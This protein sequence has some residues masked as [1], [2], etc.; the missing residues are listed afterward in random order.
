[1]SKIE[2]KTT[3]VDVTAPEI[4]LQGETHAHN[5]VVMEYGTGIRA[6]RTDKLN[7]FVIAGV[8]N[9]SIQFPS[10]GEIIIN[11]AAS[12]RIKTADTTDTAD[13]ELRTVNSRINITSE[14]PSDGGI[15]ARIRRYFNIEDYDGNALFSINL[16]STYTQ[17]TA[18]SILYLGEN[19]SVIS[20]QS[21]TSNK[22]ATRNDRVEM[23]NGTC[24]LRIKSS[25]NNTETIVGYTSSD[26]GSQIRLLKHNIRF[27]IPYSAEDSNGL[28]GQIYF[29]DSGNSGGYPFEASFSIKNETDFRNALDYIF[30]IPFGWVNAKLYLYENITLN[31]IYEHIVSTSSIGVLSGGTV[32]IIGQ[33]AKCT[34]KC[35]DGITLPKLTGVN[36]V[37]D[38][39]A[40]DGSSILP[41]P[42][43]DTSIRTSITFNRCNFRHIELYKLETKMAVHLRFIYCNID[44]LSTGWT[45][46]NT[47]AYFCNI[48]NLVIDDTDTETTP[49]ENQIICNRITNVDNSKADGRTSGYG[50][51]KN[52]DNFNT[53]NN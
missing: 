11:S 28:Y 29:N 43:T 3:S 39:L 24:H 1:M 16:Y 5:D 26:V 51:V 36:T 42:A 20:C 45:T 25:G 32:H 22:V 21:N 13:I 18:K 40:F 17:I 33:T 52:V 34:I 49:M 50:N 47:D 44:T 27:A 38:N 31:Q 37:Y 8:H 30:S 12:T 10:T 2:T 4:N 6:D 23:T 48:T 41:A 19:D 14:S 7:P 53:W 46:G 9:Q 35:G 15:S